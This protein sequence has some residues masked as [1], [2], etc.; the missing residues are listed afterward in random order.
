MS[1]DIIWMVSIVF[2]VLVFVASLWA[3]NEPLVVG[4][5]YLC[6]F[7]TGGFIVTLA[8]QREAEEE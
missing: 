5:A 6:G 8:K 2:L 3:V 4:L 1:E 7:A